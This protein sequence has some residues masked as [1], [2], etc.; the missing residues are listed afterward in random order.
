MLKILKSNCILSGSDDTG[1]VS[2]GFIVLSAPCYHRTLSFD[3]SVSG[4]YYINPQGPN[5]WINLDHPLSGY[6]SALVKQQTSSYEAYVLFLPILEFDK[7]CFCLVVRSEDKYLR[8]YIRIGIAMFTAKSGLETFETSIGE[9]RSF[10]H[11]KGGAGMTLLRGPNSEN[12][13][14]PGHDAIVTII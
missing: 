4:G 12:D 5:C 11:W 6:Q 2:S 7:M 3:D 9:R 10:I 8:T 14:R 1:K 13:T